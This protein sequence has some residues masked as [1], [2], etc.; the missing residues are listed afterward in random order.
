MLV[1]AGIS[2]MNIRNFDLNLLV[3]F[4]DLFNT[5]SVSQTATNLG[6]S[7]PG[8]CHALNRLRDSL[9]D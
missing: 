5:L 3:I 9:S 7:Q 6:L 8:V 2:H 4:K 1:I